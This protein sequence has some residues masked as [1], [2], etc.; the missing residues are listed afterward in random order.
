MGLV[1]TTAAL[2]G[3]FVSIL[4][5][6][7][8]GIDLDT[9][10]RGFKARKTALAGKLFAFHVHLQRSLCANEIS[11]D[12]SGQPT[13]SLVWWPEEVAAKHCWHSDGDANQGTGQR[14]LAASDGTDFLGN[15]SL[16]KRR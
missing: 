7:G 14:A 13:K 15:A 1:M 10:E 9:P 2:S 5:E 8:L 12:P 4:D 6:G 16:H 3:A 11:L